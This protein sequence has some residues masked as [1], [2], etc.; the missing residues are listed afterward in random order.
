MAWEMIT[1]EW[2]GDVT[3]DAIAETVRLAADYG[4]V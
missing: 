1:G 4:V 3:E 2:R